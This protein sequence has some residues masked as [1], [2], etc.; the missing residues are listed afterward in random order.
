[1]NERRQHCRVSGDMVCDIGIHVRAGGDG[2]LLNFGR[3]GAL[4]ATQR[5]LPPGSPVDVQLSA[6]PNRVTVRALVLRCSVRTIAALEGVTYEAALQFETPMDVPRAT[7][8]RDGYVVPMATSTNSVNIGS[9]L[10]GTSAAPR[11]AEREL[12][13]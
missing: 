13:K 2:A 10:P 6:G 3:G 11:R 1:M 7:N 5:P 8:A 9:V 12:V 4:M